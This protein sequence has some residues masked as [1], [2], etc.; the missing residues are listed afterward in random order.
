MLKR[1]LIPVIILTLCGA[2]TYGL[3]ATKPEVET[4]PTPTTVPLVSV[5]SVD[6][7]AVQFVVDAQGT[8]LPRTES[9]LVSRVAGE[10][11]EIAPSFEVGGFFRQGQVLLRL[12]AKD[13]EL[14]VDQAEAQVAQAELV[15]VQQEAEARIARDEW[16]SLGQGEASPLT[17]RQPQVAQAKASLAAAEAQLEKARLDL[18]RT[19][20]RAP[21]AGRVRAKLADRGQYLAPGTRVATVHAIDYAEVHLPVSVDELHYLDLPLAYRDGGSQG[22]EVTLSARVAGRVQRWSG[23]IVR[24]EGEIDPRTR[25]LNLIARIE[26]PYGRR[27]ASDSSTE[28]APLM[29]GLFVDAEI[30]GRD[31]TDVA[32]LPRKVLRSDDQVLVVDAED[33]LRFRTVEVLRT[34]GDQVII[35]EGLQVGE[36]VCVSNLDVVVDGMLVRTDEADAGP[37]NVDDG[38]DAVEVQS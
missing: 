19:V 16:D 30:H 10:V 5:E 7:Q 8:V 32:V 3:V 24:S 36:R 20:I 34:D 18:E 9:T 21:F 1:I 15:L 17:L 26:D 31:Q 27:S 14:T 38:A 23:R 33:R 12:D 28:G 25:M 35:G 13:Y 37:V 22:P 4:R 6:R 29:V 2:I 11:V